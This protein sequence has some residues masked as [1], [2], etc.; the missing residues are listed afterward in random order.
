MARGAREVLVLCRSDMI[1]L[2]RLQVI[3]KSCDEV[4]ER[5]AERRERFL[6]SEFDVFC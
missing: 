4:V 3:R 2:I 5:C 1:G 6:A